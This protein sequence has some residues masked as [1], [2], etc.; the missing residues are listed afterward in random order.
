MAKMSSVNVG[1][2]TAQPAPGFPPRKAKVKEFECGIHVLKYMATRA[3]CPACEAERKENQ[4]RSAVNEL[5]NK[6]ELVVNE[7]YRL[8]MQTDAV[9][10]IR[11][12]ATLLDDN[13]MAFLKAV[14]YEWRDKKSIGLKVTHGARKR[15]VLPPPNGFIAMPRQG[16]PYGHACTSIGGLAIAEYVDE[17]TNTFGPAK[18]MEYLVKGMAAYLPGAIQ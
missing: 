3:G 6:L 7:N 12:A 16:D 1:R 13:D 15:G 18:S 9:F 11:E 4:L 14:L 17:A 8:K 5:T 10:A 2:L